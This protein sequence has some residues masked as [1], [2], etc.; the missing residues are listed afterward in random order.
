LRFP[1]IRIVLCLAAVVFARGDTSG[2]TGPVSAYSF[3]EGGGST[4]ANASGT[5]NAGTISGATWSAA[6]RFGSALSFNGTNSWVTIADAA[7]L[8]LTTGMTLEAWIKPTALSSWRTVVMK[9]TPGDLAYVLYAYDNAPRPAVYISVSGQQSTGGGAAPALNAWTHLAAT[10]DGASLRLFTNGALV[11]TKPQAGAMVTSANPLRIGGNGVW[12]EYFSG[13]I[14]EVR[15]YNRALSQAEIQTD[16]ATPVGSGGPPPTDTTPPTVSLTQPANGAT[17]T[18]TTTLTASASDNVGV[19]GV[20]FKLDGGDLGAEVSFPYSL[21]WNTAAAASGPHTLTAVARDAAFN[22]T[23]SAA[24]AVTVDNGGGSSLV[25]QWSAP[26]EVGA[27]A[28]NMV[29]MHTGKVLLYSG[30]YTSSYT[31]RVL[32]PLT[33]S[34][35]EVPNPYYDLFCSGH[36][37][38]AD[39]RILVVGGYDSSSLGSAE[40]NIFD[41]VS[42]TWTRIPNMYYRRWYP[43]A[44]TLGDGRV[45]VTSGGQTCLTC[46]ADIPEI[47]NPVTNSWTRLT[48]ASWAMPYYPFTYLLPDGR[49]LDAG[50]NEA[51]VVTRALNIATQTWTTIDPVAVDGHSSAMYRP[52]KIIKS[53][54]ATDSGTSNGPSAATAYVLDMTA[55]SPSWRQIPSMAFARAY[56]NT[57]LLPDGSVLV[58]G[59]GSR[60]DGKNEQY[61][62]KQTELWSPVT[63]TWTTLAPAA[64]PRLYHSSALLLPDARVLV[65][66]SGNDSGMVDRTAAEIFSPPYLFRGARPA[67]GSVP[68]V[69]SYATNFLL[70]TA[71]AASV[72]SVALIRPAAVTHSF[73]EDQRFV[74]LTFVQN[75]GSLTVEAP[76]NANLAPPGYYMLFIVNSSGV[77]ST[78]AWV[79]FGGTAQDTQPPSAPVSLTAQPS[80]GTA[81]LAWTASTDDTGV[82]RYNVHRSTTAGFTPGAANKIGEA[83]TASYV[84]TGLAAGTYYFVVT[85]QDV[86]GNVSGPSNEAVALVPGDTTAPSVAMTAPAGSATVFGTLPVSATASDDVGVTSVQFTVD[87]A[88]VGSADTSAPFTIQWNSSTVPNGLHAISAVAR[89]A[90]GNSTPATAVMVDVSN[91]QQT[92]NGLVAAYSFNEAAGVSTLDASGNNNTGTISNATRSTA[93]KF[94]KALSF[95]GTSARVN[96]PDAASLDLTTGMTLEAWVRPSALTNWRTVILKETAGGLAFS[97]YAHSSASRPE[98]YVHVTTDTAVSGTSALALNTWTHLSVS[99]DGATIRLYVNGV[100]VGSQALAGP[101]VTSTG[102]LRI[103]GNA[104]W[105]EYF[106]GLI[107]EVRVYNR[108][109]SAGEIQLDMVTPIP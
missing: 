61:A 22:Q 23:T 60:L 11:S 16:M 42:L 40:A 58:T 34:I 56:H 85:A 52:G 32:D 28:V 13:L 100:Q 49:V 109:L 76:A 107:D 106:K 88:A 14:D 53:G 54:T 69:L 2:Q 101:I 33:G 27:V 26:I 46:L 17:V 38:L 3:D 55:P 36:A 50:A 15:V 75:G 31:E 97:L 44:T 105:G 81:A 68:S 4:V 99:Y 66:G 8:D 57:T 82:A 90:A 43:S 108:A 94:G 18:A 12:G 47:Y 64:T 77:P 35:T 83:T 37:Q 45:L 6:G 5:G 1:C 10:Y 30:A 65:A 62:V 67:I 48:G 95:N 41:P 103:G 71:D 87:D 86:A 79:R 9:E 73:D 92:P 63:E 102:A 21:S 20:Q 25:G 29:M 98:G 96:V 19:V 78:A 7:S 72:A 51:A 80:F 74:P 93:G 104:V 70:Q 59:G 89:D 91:T 84:N 39:G 24:V